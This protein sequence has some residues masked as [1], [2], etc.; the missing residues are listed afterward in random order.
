MVP[1][2]SDQGKRI[3][4]AIEESSAM[5]E[6]QEMQQMQQSEQMRYRQMR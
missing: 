1:E 5:Q 4:L 3:R 6:L 2:V